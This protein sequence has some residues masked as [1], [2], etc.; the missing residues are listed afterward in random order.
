[1][2]ATGITRTERRSFGLISAFLVLIGLNTTAWFWGEHYVR[3]LL[4]VYR[5]SFEMLTPHFKVKSLRIEQENGERIVKVN[6]Q[7]AS[8]RKLD[9]NRVQSGIPVSSSTLAGHALQHVI[10]LFTLISLWPVTL[11]WERGILAVLAIPALMMVEV[12]D[13]PVVLAGSLEDLVLF[14]FAPARLSSSFLVQGMHF[15][16]GGGRLALSFVAAALT[17]AAW[18]AMNKHFR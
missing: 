15:M 9:G 3:I 1:M 17:I 4:P 6:A 11:L 18:R 16:N 8:L 5:W 14:N 13:I 2:G 7:T 10:I 12:L